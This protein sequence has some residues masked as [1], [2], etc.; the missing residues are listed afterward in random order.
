MGISQEIQLERLSVAMFNPPNG[1]GC[2]HVSIKHCLSAGGML[3]FRPGFNQPA[4]M[5]ADYSCAV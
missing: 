1:K 5:A 3:C 4:P 2:L